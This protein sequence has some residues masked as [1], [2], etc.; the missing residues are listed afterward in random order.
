M[1]GGQQ[2]AP[3]PFS[4]NIS[5]QNFD[6]A[7]L[8]KIAQ[9]LRTIPPGLTTPLSDPE[10]RTISYASCTLLRYRVFKGRA[11]EQT[12][13]GCHST[14]DRKF[15]FA[16]EDLTCFSSSCYRMSCY[17][18]QCFKKVSYS[19]LTALVFH[20]LFLKNYERVS[21]FSLSFFFFTIGWG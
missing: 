9:R 17:R 1:I 3:R 15:R 12:L 10:A 8:F 7:I 5:D 13:E 6:K 14:G 11:V 20:Q 4:P 21:D 18:L 19:S 2:A 16:F